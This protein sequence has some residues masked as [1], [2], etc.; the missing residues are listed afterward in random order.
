MNQPRRYFFPKDYADV[1]QRLRVPLG[2]GLVAAFA[3]WA[4]PTRASLWVGLP[5]A[6]CGVL[7]R[8]WAAGHLEKNSVLAITGPYAHVRNPLYVGT[9]MTA[10]GLAIAARELWLAVLF[11]ASFLLV[12]L[13]AIEL[14]EQHLRKLFPDYEQ[15]AQLVPMLRPRLW[16]AVTGGRFRFGQYRKNR[17]YEALAGF[18]AGVVYLAWRAGLFK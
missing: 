16:P 1:V 9:L 11:A 17:E 10:M 5:V 2:F 15:Y 14:E 8:A 13:P 6:A 7:I 18:L 12:Y 3:Y 4:A